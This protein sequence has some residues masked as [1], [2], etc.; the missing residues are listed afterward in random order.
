MLYSSQV[1]LLLDYH[2]VDKMQPANVLQYCI[3]GNERL[4]LALLRVWMMVKWL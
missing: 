2:T 3:E 4:L 1:D